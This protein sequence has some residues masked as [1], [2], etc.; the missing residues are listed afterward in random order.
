M[1]EF[2]LAD[3]FQS[4]SDLDAGIEHIEFIYSAI[5]LDQPVEVSTVGD[6]HNEV[7]VAFEMAIVVDLYN[8]GVV[9]GCLVFGFTEKP[10]HSVGVIGKFRLH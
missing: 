10:S 2:F 7:F 3:E 6:L 9:Q 4:T 8:V 5:F 1:D